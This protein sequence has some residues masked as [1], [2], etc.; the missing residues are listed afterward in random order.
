MTSE[1]TTD[2]RMTSR[3]SPRMLVVD[4][5]KQIREAITTWFYQRGFYV[6]EAENGQR[7][8]EICQ[9]ETFDI[10][11]M[12]MEMPVMKGPEAIR[13]LRGLHPEIPILVFTG[14]SDLIDEAAEV[15]A[16]RI[17]QKPLGLRDLEREVRNVL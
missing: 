10:V 16:N 2:H 5:E 3:P 4:D 9:E 13:A 14:Y 7:A 8:V 12:D 11:L 6:R 15:G 17:L 1:A